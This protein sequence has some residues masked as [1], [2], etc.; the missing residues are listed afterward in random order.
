MLFPLVS[1]GA[2]ACLLIIAI[3]WGCL[4]AA[5]WS[6]FFALLIPSWVNVYVGASL[7]DMRA[8]AFV[9]AFSFHLLSSEPQY[10]LRIT[11]TDLVVLTLTFAVIGAQYLSGDLIPTSIPS[12]LLIWTTPYIFGRLLASVPNAVERLS[13]VMLCV[14]VVIFGLVAFEAVSHINPTNTLLGRSGSYASVNGNRWGMRRAEGISKHP[15]FMGM[16]IAGLFPWVLAAASEIRRGNVLTKLSGLMWILG[17]AIVIASIVFPLSR[18]PILI[19]LG[20]AGLSAFLTIRRIRLPVIALA[21]AVAI[22]V[23]A[24]SGNLVQLLEATAQDTNQVMVSINGERYPYTGTNHRFLLFL[25]YQDAIKD[26]GAFGFGNFSLEKPHLVHYVEPHLRQLF[27]SIDNHYLLTLLNYGYLGVGA[28]LMLSLGGVYCAWRLY[29]KGGGNAVVNQRV[30][31][32]ALVG[33]FLATSVML[34]TVWLDSDFGFLLL[35][36]IGFVSTQWS[37]CRQ[38]IGSTT[39]APQVN[40]ASQI[41]RPRRIA[42][43]NSNGLRPARTKGQ[44]FPYAG[45]SMNTGLTDSAR[46]TASHVDTTYTS[47]NDS[48][49]HSRGFAWRFLAVALVSVGAGALA[50][51]LLAPKLSTDKWVHR[52]RLVF[53][54]GHIPLGSYHA[55]K[56]AEIASMLQSPG[57]IR[58]AFED[59]KHVDQILNEL[60]VRTIPGSSFVSLRLKWPEKEEGKQILESIVS[61][62]QRAV[63]ELRQNRIDAIHD[64]LSASQADLA[65]QM[66][67]EKEAAALFYDEHDTVSVVEDLAFARSEILSLERELLEAEADRKG[68]D[69]QIELHTS[70]N[71]NFAQIS[72]PS[73]ARPKSDERHRTLKR[74]IDERRE[75]EA[76][77]ITKIMYDNQKVEVE[78][79]RKLAE[80]RL[81][82]KA[83][84][85]EAELELS[86]LEVKHANSNSHQE[87]VQELWS[88]EDQLADAETQT[89][90]GFVPII[91]EQ[92][93]NKERI[94]A[95]KNRMDRFI[96]E[97]ARLRTLLGE[98]SRITDQLQ[99]LTDQKHDLDRKQKALEALLNSPVNRLTVGDAPSLDNPPIESNKKKMF[100]AVFA[101]V[102]GIV[103]GPFL[104]FDSLMVIRR[105]N[106]EKLTNI[107]LG[108]LISKTNQQYTDSSLD[109]TAAPELLVAPP[110]DIRRMINQL[111]T[112]IGDDPYVLAFA[113]M[114]GKPPARSMMFDVAR[115]FARHGRNV[116][117]TMVNPNVNGDDEEAQ[118]NCRQDQLYARQSPA[119][120]DVECVAS[121]GSAVAKLDRKRDEFDLVIIA[122]GVEASNVNELDLLSFYADGIVASDLGRGKHL[123]RRVNVVRHVNSSEGNILGIIP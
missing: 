82:S 95:L 29:L 78:R 35:F 11:S 102:C 25:V 89:Q 50:A 59:A 48:V 2:V 4:C 64:E 21:A 97:E 119:S 63:D 75:L 30:F 88:L 109:P 47:A 5:R 77:A 32:A 6:L 92:I 87:L 104:L 79:K 51:V 34:F 1:I 52:S 16:I 113:G 106:T 43:P 91:G 42:T 66:S 98:E 33:Y 69:R 3:R 118:K 80:R 72:L 103:F 112:V 24:N 85:Q 10:R 81:I 83:E 9:L 116:Q 108:R 62:S 107:G 8:V 71:E 122:A 44:S 40:S 39:L 17:P 68:I 7:I 70:I 120:F 20:T 65:V 12:V 53:H 100:A 74:K 114:D 117:L 56:L 37:L 121:V 101:G 55:P 26:A 110:A 38:R 73:Q 54:E 49:Q 41:R 15:I 57:T 19:L 46:L 22:F 27:R 123:R 36:N 76:R 31:H 18:G 94:D 86:L 28:F 67:N 14:A 96:A 105:R 58:P 23:I 61:Q 99:V 45:L 84:L 111:F 93:A 13:V 115:C 60:E 90:N